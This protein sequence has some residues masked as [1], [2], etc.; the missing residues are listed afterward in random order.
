MIT[1]NFTCDECDAENEDVHSDDKLPKGWQE[2]SIAV[3]GR[4]D[5]AVD[6]EY[7]LHHS[8]VRHLCGACAKSLLDDLKSDKVDQPAYVVPPNPE[9]FSAEG[10]ANEECERCLR[11]HHRDAPC[12]TF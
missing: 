4:N 9:H 10:Q 6:A 12:D 5:V 8:V 7:Q 3:L 11:H 2:I 1:R